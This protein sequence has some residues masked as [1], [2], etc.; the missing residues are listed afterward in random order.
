MKPVFKDLV[1]PVFNKSVNRADAALLMEKICY[2][3]P[4][5]DTLQLVMGYF[6]GCEI[7]LDLLGG[8]RDALLKFS[9]RLPGELKNGMDVCGTGGDG[10]NT[11]NISTLSAFVI[12]GAGVHVVKHGNFGSGS[13][14]GSSNV[15]AAAGYF[16]S[17]DPSKL[18]TEYEEA[19]ITFL[20]A[21]CFFPCLK[22][23]APIRRQIGLRTVFNA[24]GPLVNPAKPS[25]Q[26]TGVFSL[27]LARIYHQLLQE[28]EDKKYAVVFSRDGYDEVS[29]TDDAVIFGNRLEGVFPPEF[30]GSSK[31]NPTLLKCRDEKSAFEIF[32]K[33]LK[34]K[35]EKE[36]LNVIIANAALGIYLRFPGKSFEE[37]RFMAE[38]SVF[39][40][41]AVRT[42]N[43]LIQLQKHAN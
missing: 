37:C 43:K 23:L 1:A 39:S 11:L 18:S 10:K 24:L 36:I 34:G 35:A 31:I 41:A 30:F 8:F 16:F 15:M 25:F 2:G 12:A 40:G 4:E 27:K 32:C 13:V 17:G 14:S 6:A 33:A 21:P 28:T 3:E 20:H 9:P 29:L 5:S 26:F 19:G 7:S 22:P 38:S 42:F